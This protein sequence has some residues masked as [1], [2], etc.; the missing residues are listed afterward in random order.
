MDKR[1]LGTTELEIAPLIFGGNVFG[2]TVDENTSFRLLDEFLDNGFNTIDTANSYSSWVQGNH[3][4]E[5]ETIIGKWL[6][7]SGKRNQALIITKVGWDITP[8][9]KGLD[10]KSIIEEVEGSLKRLQ[11]DY[12]DL[13]FSHKDDPDTSVEE[14]L[15]TF[16]TLIKQGKVRHIGAS[17]FIRIDFGNLWKLREIKNYMNIRS[18]SPNIICMTGNLKWEMLLL[19]KN[20]NWA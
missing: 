16:D 1:K 20:T 6:K 4:G 7:Q 12:I 11:T 19:L 18:F 2:W 9:R 17:N 10:K 3:G 15:E 8:Q 14:T 5:S 13:Y